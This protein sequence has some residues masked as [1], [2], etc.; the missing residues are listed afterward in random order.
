[1]DFNSHCFLFAG[2]GLDKYLFPV[3]VGVGIVGNS[4]SFMVQFTLTFL[5]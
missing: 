3:I 2:D 1:M 4:L 5:G